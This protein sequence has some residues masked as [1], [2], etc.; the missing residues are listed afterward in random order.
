MLT[1][2]QTRSRYAG[3]LAAVAVATRLLS[4]TALPA[5]PIVFGVPGGN[6]RLFVGAAAIS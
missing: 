1:S 3:S 6:A 4:A 5:F 2:H